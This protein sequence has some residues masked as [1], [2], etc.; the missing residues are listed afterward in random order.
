[1]KEFKEIMGEV[2]AEA[3][4]TTTA[5]GA[6]GVGTLTSVNAESV[7]APLPSSTSVASDASVASGSS[8]YYSD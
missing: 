8:D 6:G 3:E 7:G 2:A 4:N 5:A 1:M